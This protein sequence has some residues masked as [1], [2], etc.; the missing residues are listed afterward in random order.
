MTQHSVVMF[1]SL[2]FLGNHCVR[3]ET[4]TAESFGFSREYTCGTIAETPAMA[5]DY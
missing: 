2:C 4:R 1:V 5:H 3:L